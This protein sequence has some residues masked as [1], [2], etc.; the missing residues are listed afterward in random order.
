[1]GGPQ[2]TPVRRLLPKRS[3]AKPLM[4]GR[5]H[6]SRSG[7]FLS[8]SAV[9][10]AEPAADAFS[11]VPADSPW[12]DLRLVTGSAGYWCPSYPVSSGSRHLSRE[13]AQESPSQ[14][15]AEPS[16]VTRVSG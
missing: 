10:I 1:M 14:E 13:T 3:P 6:L 5:P 11:D 12:L 16:G 9:S 4:S 15:G 7:S 8:P 2:G